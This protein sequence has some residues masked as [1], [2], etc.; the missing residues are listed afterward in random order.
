MP[1]LSEAP[2]QSQNS[3]ESLRSKSNTMATV[4]VL[5]MECVLILMVA[6]SPWI[7]GMVQPRFEFW[8]TVGVSCL[9]IL[10]GLKSVLTWNVKIANCPITIVLVAMFLFGMIQL[11]PLPGNLLNTI[12][13][14][15]AGLYDDLLPEKREVI[16]GSETT[17][18]EQRPVGTTLSLYPD[19]TRRWL[20]RILGVILLL[21]VVRT[22]LSSP[23]SLRRLSIVAV[24]N[25]VVISFFAL[26]QFFTSGDNSTLYW[27]VPSEGEVFGPFVNR[28]H[29]AMYINLCIGLNIGLLLSR[30]YVLRMSNNSYIRKDRSSIFDLFRDA[31]SAWMMASTAFMLSASLLSLSRGGFLS[32]LAGF[33]FCTLVLLLSRQSRPK[34]NLLAPGIILS[35]ALL[36]IVFLGWNSVNQRLA[37]IW[38]LEALEAGRLSLWSRAGPVLIKFP[39][40]GSGMGTFRYIEPMYFHTANDKGMA[41][42]HAHNEY[43]QM[44]IEGGLVQ[45]ALT[46]VGLFVAIRCCY[47]MFKSNWNTAGS[48]MAI[49]L[50]FCVVVFGIHSFGEFGIRIPA[51]ALL[52]AVILAHAS[53]GGCQIGARVRIRSQQNPDRNEQSEKSFGGG[54]APAVALICAAMF[55]VAI[56]HE[57]RRLASTA[58]SRIAVQQ[59]LELGDLPGCQKRIDILTRT[60]YI[61]PNDAEVYWE[62]AQ[63]HLDA[64]QL[65]ALPDSDS[66]RRTK[67][68]AAD[69][70]LPAMGYMQMARDL[71]P[72]LPQP[73]IRIASHIEE[74]TSIE[75][76]QNYLR[77]VKQLCPADAT[78]WFLCGVEELKD[79]PEDAWKSFKHCLSLSDEHLTS[80]LD[81]AAGY[82]DPNAM[83]SQVFPAD[84]TMILAAADHLFPKTEQGSN[85]EERINFL[86][87]ASTQLD[88]GDRTASELFAKGQIFAELD[89]SETAISAFNRALMEQPEQYVWR[90]VYAE[91]LVKTG[92]HKKAQSELRILLG[93]QQTRAEAQ[94]L[95]ATITD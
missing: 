70:L 88:P 26:L 93:H 38:D 60:T 33:L 22:E 89:H 55:A 10:W 20:I 84:P 37:T 21:L 46:L 35:L 80:I 13:P 40:F 23:S 58:H 65:K 51:I 32:L 75:P 42:V 44:W 39:L 62:L 11:I 25:G 95:L 77:R 12:A 72:L 1:E 94:Q 17:L 49:G 47:R 64:Y 74:F 78:F 50:L 6:V 29:C 36:L 27:V 9:V 8:L 76:R 86:T 16:S 45:L 53:A 66:Q 79:N 3:S 4:I 67:M 90:L 48:G 83:V 34:L 15:T 43:L 14:G 56:Y 41:Y 24:V 69:H 73:H 2:K 71:C 82:L 18:V 85:Q 31:P 52:F 92:R 28:N 61:S 81:T 87:H 54:F 30:R 5:V 91:Y 19:A 68:L 59:T 7:F 63:A 57:N